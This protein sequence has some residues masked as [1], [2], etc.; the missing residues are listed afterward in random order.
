M[1]VEMEPERY[2]FTRRERAQSFLGEPLRRLWFRLPG[3]RQREA[4][5]D[6]EMMELH[7]QIQATRPDTVHATSYEDGVWT[8]I[9]NPDNDPRIVPVAEFL[10]ID[11]SITSRRG[12]NREMKRL[13]KQRRR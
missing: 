4:R 2:Q 5:R 11:P 1:R 8:I 13:M 7:R 10:P 9:S 3:I 12:I 6:S